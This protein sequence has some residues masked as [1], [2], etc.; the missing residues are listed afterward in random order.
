MKDQNQKYI[1]CEYENKI[2]YTQREAGAIVNDC[3]RHGYRTW[4]VEHK[5]K[6]MRKYFCK[7]CRF[8]HV[9]HLKS[10]KNIPA[11]W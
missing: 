4:G 1:I 7:E 5:N 9:S 2:C 3:R 6:P 8:Y 10:F 11:D